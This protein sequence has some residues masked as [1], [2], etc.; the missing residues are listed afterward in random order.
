MTLELRHNVSSPTWRIIEYL[1]RHS[2]ATIKEFE[3]LLGVTTTAV[4][5]HLNAL[6][7]GGYIQRQTVNSGV[8]RPH[9]VYKATESMP[10]IFRL[11]L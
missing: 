8:G 2:S 3:D 6:Q 11:S 5:Q 10:R 4:R 9:H 1:Q 7:A